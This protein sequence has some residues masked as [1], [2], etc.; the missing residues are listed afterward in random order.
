MQLSCRQRERRPLK[1]HR[2][3]RPRLIQRDT[4]S[5]VS[6]SAKLAHEFSNCTDHILPGPPWAT[7]APRMRLVPRMET[8]RDAPRTTGVRGGAEG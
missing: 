5:P 2:Y 8:H 3:R 6:S 7:A 1:P 4:H